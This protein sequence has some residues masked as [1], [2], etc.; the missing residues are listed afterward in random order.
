[1]SLSHDET[2]LPG[3][4]YSMRMRG[5]AVGYTTNTDQP[6]IFHGINSTG[7][8][9]LECVTRNNTVPGSAAFAQEPDYKVMGVVDDANMST[10]TIGRFVHCGLAT[11]VF[12]HF[13]A[14]HGEHI[15]RYTTPTSTSYFKRTLGP[16]PGKICGFIMDAGGTT[17]TVFILPWR[18]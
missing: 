4:D 16:A 3:D 2:M 18:I 13:P 9:E 8:I 1:M 10:T 17:R 11:N 14:N 12:L 7:T 15:T 6:L 5:I